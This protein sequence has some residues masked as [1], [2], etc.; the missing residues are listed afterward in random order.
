MA[1]RPQ[2][3]ATTIPNSNGAVTCAAWSE[4][5]T[6]AIPPEATPGWYWLFLRNSG[7][8]QFGGILFCVSDQDIKKPILVVSSEAT[9]GAAYNGYHRRPGAVLDL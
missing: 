9:W 2:P 8:T 4:N 3:A 5:V 6:W 1:T 7:G